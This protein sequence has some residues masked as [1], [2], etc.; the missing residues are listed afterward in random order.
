M[1]KTSLFDTTFEGL[2]GAAFVVLAYVCWIFSLMYLLVGILEFSV[3]GL[4]ISL[5]LFII[6]FLFVTPVVEKDK[7]EL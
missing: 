5:I 3:L 2:C 1:V 4:I 7:R 6:G